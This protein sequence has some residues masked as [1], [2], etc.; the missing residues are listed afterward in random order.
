MVNLFNPFPLNNSLAGSSRFFAARLWQA[1]LRGAG[2]RGADFRKASLAEANLRKA[3]LVEADLS[4]AELYGA[5][6]REA[7]FTG[8]NLENVQV[9][10]KTDLR[11]AKELND[12]QIQYFKDKGALIDEA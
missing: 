2:F 4:E 11:G 9:S 6:L 1:D 7:D 12:E 5:D 10:K 3:S 8:A